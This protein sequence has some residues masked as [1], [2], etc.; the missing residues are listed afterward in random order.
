MRRLVLSWSWTRAQRR[1]NIQFQCVG[2]SQLQP[3]GICLGDSRR[4]EVHLR[5]WLGNPLHRPPWAISSWPR[6]GGTVEERRLSTSTW[7]R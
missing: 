6:V 2:P 5:S 4:V 1:S 7:D 3:C